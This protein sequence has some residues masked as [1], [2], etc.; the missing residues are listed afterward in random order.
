VIQET[1]K[2]FQKMGKV[3]QEGESDPGGG[4]ATKEEGKQPWRGGKSRGHCSDMALWRHSL[5]LFFRAHSSLSA[6]RALM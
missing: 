2:V 6:S 1:G 5:P 4:K 3:T